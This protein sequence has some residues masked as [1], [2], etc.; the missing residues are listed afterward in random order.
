MTL[1]TYENMANPELIEYCSYVHE[2]AQAAITAGSTILIA[3]TSAEAIT[4]AAGVTAVTHSSGIPILTG[5][6]GY[7]AG[8]YAALG[9]WAAAAAPILATGAMIAGGIT[10]GSLAICGIL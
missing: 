6:T 9:T 5:S 8:S 3:A 10:L 2:Y 1:I 4:S 7:L